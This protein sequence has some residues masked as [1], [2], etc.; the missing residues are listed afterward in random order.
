MVDEY[1]GKPGAVMGGEMGMPLSWVAEVA[2]GKMESD[3]GPIGV[4]VTWLAY[5]DVRVTGQRVVDEEIV[6]VTTDVELAGQSVI[7]GG[8]PVIVISFV[9]KTTDCETAG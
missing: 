1:D 7:E 9:M 5:E 8:Q 2:G 6:E 4:R 3:P